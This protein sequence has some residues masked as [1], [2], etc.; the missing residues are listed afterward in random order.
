M[1]VP[2]FTDTQAVQMNARRAPFDRIT[3]GFHWATVLIVLALFASAWLHAQSH[4]DAL[5]A[6]VLQIH[7][8]L[9]LTIWVATA[10]R[11]IWRT[12]N[13]RLPPFPTDMTMIHRNVVW[14]SEYCLYAL[15][16]SQPASG[17]GATLLSGHRFAVFGWEIP[18][19]MPENATL[20]LAFFSAHKLGALALGVL[21]AGHAAAALVHH[22]VLRDDVLQ[23]MAPAITA[24]RQKPEFFPGRVIRNRYL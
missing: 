4:N 7:R 22:F 3:I 14:G 20:Q 13:A 12:T 23:C 15:L 2:Q 1:S 10:F 9:G 24:E 5:K 16:L 8:S 17:L 6:T 18:Q 21:V 19:L 11:L